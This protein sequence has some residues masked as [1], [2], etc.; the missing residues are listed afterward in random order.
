[1]NEVEVTSSSSLTFKDALGTHSLQ[2]IASAILT[3]SKSKM[4]MNVLIFISAFVTPLQLLASSFVLPYFYKERES[5]HSIGLRKFFC[6]FVRII[7]YESANVEVLL[8][9]RILFFVLIIV[10]VGNMLIYF[11]LYYFKKRL[12]EISNY[13]FI[14]LHI[15]CRVFVPWVASFLAIAVYNLVKHGDHNSFILSLVAFIID[16]LVIWYGKLVLSC[17]PAFYPCMGSRWAE[18]IFTDIL[19]FVIFIIIEVAHDI[20][21]NKT[22]NI[23]LSSVTVAVFLLLFSTY[24]RSLVFTYVQ[25]NAYIWAI[26]FIT[27]VG[28]CWDIV[29]ICGVDNYLSAFQITTIIFYPV[30]K[31][32]YV[33]ALHM[34]NKVLVQILEAD[35]EG[36]AFLDINSPTKWVN[37]SCS[38]FELLNYNLSMIKFGM[39]KFPENILIATTYLKLA[40]ILPNPQPSALSY[41][42]GELEKRAKGTSTDIIVLSTFKMEVAK[43]DDGSTDT[44]ARYIDI[45]KSFVSSFLSYT[46]QFWK[47]INASRSNR[48]A[49]LAME[50]HERYKSAINMIK[51]LKISGSYIQ[52]LRDNLPL[53]FFGSSFDAED[54]IATDSRLMFHIP[55]PANKA[56]EENE[57]QK[58][59]YY[60]TGKT[61]H[62]TYAKKFLILQKLSLILPYIFTALIIVCAFVIVHNFQV[63][64][65]DVVSMMSQFTDV[66]NNLTAMLYASAAGWY[67]EKDNLS[68]EMFLNTYTDDLYPSKLLN[69]TGDIEDITL[70]MADQIDSLY[71]KFDSFKYF[72]L[73]VY[74]E[75]DGPISFKFADSHIRKFGFFPALLNSLVFSSYLYNITEA[76]Y[77]NSYENSV[78]VIN[79]IMKFISTSSV[80]IRESMKETVNKKVSTLLI[81]AYVVMGVLLIADIGVIQYL[82]SCY[83]KYFHMLMMIPK[84]RISL[85]IEKIEH[86]MHKSSRIS[87]K[88]ESTKAF[89][90]KQMMCQTPPRQ[91]ATSTE[92]SILL[93]FHAIL[94]E[95]ITIG[96]MLLFVNS[97]EN[98]QSEIFLGVE[99]LTFMSNV[100]SLITLTGSLVALKVGGNETQ[101]NVCTLLNITYM[102]LMY[103]KSLMFM[104]NISEYYTSDYIFEET[105]NNFHS[106]A[107]A[108]NALCMNLQIFMNTDRNYTFDDPVIKEIFISLN[109]AWQMIVPTQYD[110]IVQSSEEEYAKQWVDMNSMTLYVV[111]VLCLMIYFSAAILTN[112]FLIDDFV[113]IISLTAAYLLDGTDTPLDDSKN[114]KAKKFDLI[115]EL[116]EEAFSGVIDPTFLIDSSNTI[117][118]ASPSVYDTFLSRPISGVTK[119]DAFLAQ[120][121][122]NIECQLPPQQQE[123]LSAQRRTADGSVFLF[124]LIL[125]PI[126][127]L[128]LNDVK[129]DYALIIVDKTIKKGIAR[130]MV[131]ENAIL[132]RTIASFVPTG[133]THKIAPFLGVAY[134]TFLDDAVDNHAVEVTTKVMEFANEGPD[135]QPI[136][137]SLQS[138]RVVSGALTDKTATQA[139]NDLIQFALKIRDW[140]LPFNYRYKITISVYENAFVES[141]MT[142]APHFDFLTP[143][144][145]QDLEVAIYDQPMILLT[146]PAFDAVYDLGYELVLSTKSVR[147][148]Q[149][150]EVY[151][152]V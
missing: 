130:R 105:K 146:R 127:D 74:L 4:G 71:Q 37:Y 41:G 101:L 95:A 103:M 93:I 13:A 98:R 99:E 91:F 135:L 64:P 17:A 111:L 97:M 68:N 78:T 66:S 72:N 33:I 9:Q 61:I 53:P 36:F 44:K 45:T 60:L 100:S 65:R 149:R 136:F 77:A 132:D 57:L 129:I 52:L 87:S 151:S 81:A 20:Q 147:F 62:E 118:Y 143:R 58:Q 8:C 107:G 108:I 84:N 49:S 2:R 31:I 29:Y 119:I 76:E 26:S 116:K 39:E 144:I 54:P 70:K 40:M 125:R 86:I 35:E 122:V 104:D 124:K 121:G 114:R 59:S 46:V 120:N 50:T 30:Y 150:I 18:N 92:R 140:A 102:N 148:G 6:F 3:Y 109:V 14:L 138:F 123:I 139:V 42:L 67:I 90:L 7:D 56:N 79:R 55:I 82:N 75:G 80:P 152:I 27:L 43:H 15:I 117:R 11:S 137:R 141:D 96:V 63:Y 88:I 110:M 89:Y 69:Y 23:V 38:G 126:S 47:E 106:L 12:F 24:S 112:R 22:L 21:S 48:A 51:E 32:C 1:M 16:F 85:M 73:S 128:I 25:V 10:F 28:Y 94:I 131:R 142:I 83:N 145:T 134:I 133:F 115:R 5:K 19:S 113:Q 34:N